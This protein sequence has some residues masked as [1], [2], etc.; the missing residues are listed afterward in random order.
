MRTPPVFRPSVRLVRGRLRVVAAV[1]G[2]V[3]GLMTLAPVEWNPYVTVPEH[4]TPEWRPI[5][6]VVQELGTGGHPLVTILQ[7]VGN[8]VLFVP[9]GALVPALVPWLRRGG[10]VILAGA[11]VSVLIELWQLTMPQVRHSD[12]NDVITNTLGVALGWGVVLAARRRSSQATEATEATAE[13]E[14]TVGFVHD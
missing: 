7:V 11:A 2:A 1:Y 6:P 5:V 14:A 3:L 4:N 8:V 10:R 12:V 9:F 13:A